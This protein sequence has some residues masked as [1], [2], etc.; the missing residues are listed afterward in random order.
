MEYSSKVGNITASTIA[1]AN[2]WQK[3]ASESKA[4]RKWF[5]KARRSTD[6]SFDLAFVAVPGDDYLTT[7]GPGFTF[8][9]TSLPDIYVR[10]ATVNT[11]IEIL[12][13]D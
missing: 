6:N 7:D 13:F 5:I 2:T 9:N 3:I 8:D 12:T 1:A 10:S 4:M 11:V